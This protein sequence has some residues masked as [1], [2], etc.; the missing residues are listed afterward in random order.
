MCVGRQGGGLLKAYK[1]GIMLS[2]QL[3]VSH[4]GFTLKTPLFES[5]SKASGL[6]VDFDENFDPN[7]FPPWCVRFLYC[8]VKHII[9]LFIVREL[10]TVQ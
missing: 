6:A 3:A 10:Y 4:E 5:Y 9:T 8:T 2:V 7:S 1:D